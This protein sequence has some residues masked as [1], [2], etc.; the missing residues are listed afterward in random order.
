M[1]SVWRLWCNTTSPRKARRLTGRVAAALGRDIEP[2]LIE[3]RSRKMIEATFEL[4]HG[5]QPWND[6]V[7]EIIALG[8]R[9]AYQWILTGDVRRQLEG[10]SNHAAIP[11]IVAMHWY[12]EDQRLS[13]NPDELHRAAFSPP[14]R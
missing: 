10:W 1:S 6:C 3:D 4:R 12:C 7:I 9:V 2:E 5:R 11:G 8:Q 14:E 13:G